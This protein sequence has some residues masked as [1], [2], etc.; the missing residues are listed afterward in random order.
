MLCRLPRHCLVVQRSAGRALFTTARY[1]ATKDTPIRRVF[2]FR[3]ETR[4]QRR[5]R[6]R[7]LFDPSFPAQSP[8][9]SP[10][11]S[12]DQ[13]SL[14]LD[15]ARLQNY[16]PTKTV[17]ETPSS[18]LERE[19]LHLAVYS[20]PG[21]RGSNLLEYLI[22]ERLRRPNIAHYEALILL[23]ASPEYGSA[24]NVRNLLKEMENA[25]MEANANIYTAILRTM[26]VHPD[27]DIV[28][29]VIEECDK[30]WIALDSEM[31][32][33]IAAAYL[34]AGMPELAME[35]LDT[36]EGAESTP[37]TSG[38]PFAATPSNMFGKV[39]LWLYVLFIHEFALH[40]DWESVMR[41]CYRLDDD[42]SLGIPF[43]AR[44]V[45]VPFPFW[46]WL[47]RRAAAA[48]EP[49]V[50]MWIWDIWVRR[51]WI[52]P[53]RE[54]F[55]LIFN[56]CAENGFQQAGRDVILLYEFLTAP[57]AARGSHHRP[58]SD[59]SDPQDGAFAVAYLEAQDALRKM[60]QRDK[61]LAVSHWWMFEDVSRVEDDT[62]RPIKMDP[63]AF[64][65]N[66]TDPGDAWPRILQERDME[67]ER[68]VLLT[69]KKKM[70]R[71]EKEID[72][73]LETLPRE[74]VDDI[75]ALTALPHSITM[76]S[77][78]NGLLNL[79]TH[80]AG[81]S[82][83][84]PLAALVADEHDERTRGFHLFE[85]DPNDVVS[86]DPVVDAAARREAP[87]LS[88]AID[89]TT[90]DNPAPEMK[91]KSF[92]LVAAEETI[93]NDTSAQE[94]PRRE[95][96]AQSIGAESKLRRS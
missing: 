15:K 37:S 22:V 91:A 44:Q 93:D 38:S 49:W 89:E 4:E 19:M 58:I 3:H 73:A 70:N 34:R 53:D 60:S 78:T 16:R 56:T 25:G 69:H 12:S 81:A 31:L 68:V 54:L 72:E 5:R 24:D 82:T 8:G 18:E 52:R 43:A 86:W 47:L 48:K 14:R 29:K 26:V 76:D 94:R 79:K 42:M 84:N 85:D 63:W 95:N 33:F 6:E 90:L 35:Y 23:N 88:P 55:R 57:Q 92:H 40:N 71:L 96:G 65:T 32:H 75:E 39:D 11:Q 7:N 59:A 9:Q 10:G 36:L 30:L 1:N 67:A 45:D 87:P 80:E 13:S 74:M 61:L 41:L 2:S 62:G 20:P 50:T 66:E 28:T 51:A 27:I 83:S 17:K 21:P 46:E 77:D 64:L